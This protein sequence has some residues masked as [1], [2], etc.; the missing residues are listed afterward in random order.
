M[1]IIVGGAQSLA[2]LAERFSNQFSKQ[3]PQVGIEIRRVNSSYAI[4]AVRKGE[5]QIGLV[6][7]SLSPSERLEFR[8]EALGHDALILLSYPWNSVSDLTLEQLR[9]IY[10]GQ[11]TSWNELGGQ[12]QGIVPLTREP[13]SALHR[14]FIESLFGKGFRGQEKA[15]VLRANKN[16]VLR[17]IKR[18]R[19]SIGYGIVRVEEAQS[20]GIKVLAIDGKLPTAVN[21]RDERYPFIRAR[22]V[23]SKSEPHALVQEWVAEFAKFVKQGGGGEY[24]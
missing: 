9:K 21:I 20:E 11:I 22:L 13:T 15:F 17:T 8:V 24:P 12:D 6:A 16:K 19:G 18:I 3:H 23:I 4:S 7:R 1:K 10:S 14:V 2:G 5:I